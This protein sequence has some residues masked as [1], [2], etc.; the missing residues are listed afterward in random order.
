MLNRIIPLFYIPI[1][2]P[3]KK[4]HYN[5]TD[6]IVECVHVEGY[7][8]TVKF[9]GDTMLYD[10]ETITCEPDVIDFNRK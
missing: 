6:Y 7:R 5:G 3:G 2:R 4:I 10:A 1:F 8:L 9:E